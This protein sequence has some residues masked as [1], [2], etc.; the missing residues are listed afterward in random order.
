MDTFYIF[1]LAS[2]HNKYITAGVGAQLQQAVRTQREQISRK[3]K[4]KKTWQKLVYVEAVRGVDEALVRERQIS[5]YSRAQ[6]EGLIE[7]VNPG[8]DSIS[9]TALEKSGFSNLCGCSI[10]GLVQ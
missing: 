4:R 1:L 8:W 7:S 9:L 2:R 5:R 6:L 10:R 3:L